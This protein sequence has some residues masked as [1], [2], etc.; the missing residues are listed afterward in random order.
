MGITVVDLM[1]AVTAGI[2]W[3]TIVALAVLINGACV[4]CIVKLI[5]RRKSNE[6]QVDSQGN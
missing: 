3:L 5:H 2:L 4:Y 6:Q 1:A